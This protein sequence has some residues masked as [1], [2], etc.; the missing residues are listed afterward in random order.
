MAKRLKFQEMLKGLRQSLAEVPEHRTGRNTQY[1]IP[2]AGLGAFAVFYL[3]SPSFLV[4][5]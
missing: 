1:E 3:Q 2:D 4:L 5:S